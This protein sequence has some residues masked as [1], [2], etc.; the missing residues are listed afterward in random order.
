M[1]MIK[2]WILGIL[3]SQQK[4]QKILEKGQLK[5]LLNCMFVDQ[6]KI[7]VILKIKQSIH[8][9]FLFD[10]CHHQMLLHQFINQDRNFKFLNNIRFQDLSIQKFNANLV[11]QQCRLINKRL[12]QFQI[13]LN[14]LI[15]QY[16]SNTTYKILLQRKF[17]KYSLYLDHFKIGFGKDYKVL[18]IDFENNEKF[19]LKFRLIVLYLF[20]T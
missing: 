17:I 19:F 13:W 8:P 15:K 20:R 7:R 10:F 6:Q 14:F 5:S 2:Q 3:K 11:L 12:Q 18:L 4:R 1:R 16:M 9:I